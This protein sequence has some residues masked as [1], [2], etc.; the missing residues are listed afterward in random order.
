MYSKGMISKT[1]QYGLVCILAIPLTFCE[2]T[3]KSATSSP[4]K[5]ENA[6]DELIGTTELP[7]DTSKTGL[8]NFFQTNAHR[9]WKAEPAIHQSLGPHGYVRSFFNAKVSE[10][11]AAKKTSHPKDSMIIKELYE[12]D[13]ETLKGFA[14]MVKVTEGASEDT[15]LWYEG[16]APDYGQ[17]HGTGLSNCTGCHASGTDYVTSALPE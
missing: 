11:L 6:A 13:G 12:N 9:Q 4:T 17:Y 8:L 2:S 5:S 3:N 10:S 14:A 16:F 1:I 15:W 7:S